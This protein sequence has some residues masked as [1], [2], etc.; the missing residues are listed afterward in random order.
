M[1]VTVVV[2]PVVELGSRVYLNIDCYPPYL[3][4]FPPAPFHR[5]PTYLAFLPL[6]LSYMPKLTK[7]PRHHVHLLPDNTPRS[8][9]SHSDLRHR[10]RTLILPILPIGDAIPPSRRPSCPTRNPITTASD[11]PIPLLYDLPPMIIDLLD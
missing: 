8:S 7:I 1:L 11:I 4:S 2:Q 3:L 5:I 6:P 10:N 9:R